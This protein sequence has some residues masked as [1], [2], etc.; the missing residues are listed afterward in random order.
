KRMDRDENTSTLRKNYYESFEKPADSNAESQNDLFTQSHIQLEP[1]ELDYS[2]KLPSG[3]HRYS[4]FSPFL[5]EG[6]SGHY[7][8]PEL[9]ISLQNE[10]RNTTEYDHG[11]YV[12]P[13]QT[14]NIQRNSIVNDRREFHLDIVSD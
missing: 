10:Y 11:D 9:D 2:V 12:L 5:K 14:S 6:V 8:T 7:F 3:E 13:L 1:S 4:S